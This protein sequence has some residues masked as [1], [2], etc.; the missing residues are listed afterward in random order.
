MLNSKELMNYTKDLS[1]LFVE[2]HNDLRE[3]VTEILSTFFKKVDYAINGEDALKKYKEYYDFYDKK[4]YD[5]IISDIRMPR[6]NG[7]ELVE[8]IY[9]INPNQNI[10]IVSAHDDSKYLLP[11][12]NLGI[13]QFIK[14][15]LDYQAFLKTL[16]D[17]ARNVI[18]SQKAK[19]TQQNHN[20]K[21]LSDFITFSKENN[22]LIDNNNIVALTKY[23]I[24]FLQLLSDNIGKIYSNEDITAYYCSFNETLDI[25]NIRKLVSKL[26]KKI[27]KNCI[28]SVYGVG[29]RLLPHA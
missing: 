7:V 22:I 21:R 27:S 29:Y 8:G 10:I 2:D 19:L 18:L 1:I 12:I 6:L 20:L 5:I 15:P 17:T 11:L 4:Y 23:E 13:E 16:L 24:L 28:D 25:V 14:K 9:N 3:N 26:R